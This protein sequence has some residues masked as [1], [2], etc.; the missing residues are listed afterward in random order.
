[1]LWIQ[2]G[3]ATAVVFSG[4]QIFGSGFLLPNLGQVIGH[5]E[6]HLLGLEHVVS[7]TELMYP[8]ANALGSDPYGI[9]DRNL[10]VGQVVNGSVI[11]IDGF[12]Q[13]SDSDLRCAIGSSSGVQSCSGADALRKLIIDASTF[14]T[15]YDAKISLLLPGS[16]GDTGATVLDIGTIA[17]GTTESFYLPQFQ[18]EQL[19]FDGSSTE[20]GGTNIFAGGPNGISGDLTDPSTFAIGLG[21]NFNFYEMNADG[22]FSNFGAGSFATGVPEPTTWAMVLL[23]FA[24]LGF[25]GYRGAGRA[26]LAA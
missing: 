21:G 4:N 7:N 1:M 8:L 18:G 9:S 26:A 2:I 11:P 23:G 3:N 24:G 25:A 14:S 12:A 22:S 10:A 16:D 15:M 13:N 20:G 5:E 19:V 6:G 17:P